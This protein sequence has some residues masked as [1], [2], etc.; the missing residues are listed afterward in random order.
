MEGFITPICENMPNYAE[1]AS[2]SARWSRNIVK[3]RKD[4][5]LM[6]TSLN[7][8]VVGSNPT[9]PTKFSK[10]FQDIVEVVAG[11]KPEP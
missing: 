1:I 9:A 8:R 10:L 11:T 2:G 3:Y 6:N 7:Q 4:V 5:D